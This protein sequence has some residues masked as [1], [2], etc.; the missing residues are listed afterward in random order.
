MKNILCVAVIVQYSD[1]VW[2]THET[3]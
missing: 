2:C 1:R 3:S